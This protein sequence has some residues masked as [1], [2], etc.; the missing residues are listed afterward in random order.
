MHRRLPELSR[1]TC[2]RVDVAAVDRKE[3]STAQATERG[4]AVWRRLAT[5]QALASGNCCVGELAAPASSPPSNPRLSSD[6]DPPA[7]LSFWLRCAA[8]ECPRPHREGRRSPAQIK[9]RVNSNKKQPPYRLAPRTRCC[10]V[11]PTVRSLVS[12]AVARWQVAWRPSLPIA[13]PPLFVSARAVPPWALS[14]HP[15]D[16]P[17]PHTLSSSRSRFFPSHIDRRRTHRQPGFD[18]GHTA[19]VPPVHISAFGRSRRRFCK[20][21]FVLDSSVVAGKPRR[22][23][24][25]TFHTIPLP[26]VIIL[27]LQTPPSD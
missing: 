7:F 9:E 18:H 14:P 22:G 5:G 24:S 23:G 3:E 13:V 4:A 11:P 6:F 1:R 10:R 12:V 2:T 16:P 20:P 27:Q 26:P 19:A 17:P 15:P 21:S 8:R 25:T